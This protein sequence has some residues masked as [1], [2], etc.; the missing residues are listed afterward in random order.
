MEIARTGRYGKEIA[1]DISRER[2]KRFFYAEDA[3]YRLIKDVREMCIFSTHSLIKNPPYSRLDMISCR[4]LLI[5]FDSHLQDRLVPL[6][7]CAFRPAGFCFRGAWEC[8]SR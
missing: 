2:L 4:N 5:Y 1:T 3:N 7:H 8:I 6:F